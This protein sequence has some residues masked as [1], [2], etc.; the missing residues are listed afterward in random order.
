MNA[1]QEQ[2]GNSLEEEN[3]NSQEITRRKVVV[4][5]RTEKT[6]IWEFWTT[7]GKV[8]FKLRWQSKRSAAEKKVMKFLSK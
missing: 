1:V 2:E 4:Y 8:N 6:K 7:T 5:W 3:S